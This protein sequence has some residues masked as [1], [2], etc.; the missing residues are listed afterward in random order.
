MRLS[1]TFTPALGMGLEQREFTEASFV[2]NTSY[3]MLDIP[4]PL[5]VVDLYEGDTLVRERVLCTTLFDYT[6]SES[7]AEKAGLESIKSNCGLDDM[8]VVA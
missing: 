1:G 5:V 8:D 2:I 4:E 3:S 6:G 7:G